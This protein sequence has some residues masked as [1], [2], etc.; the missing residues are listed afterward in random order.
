MERRDPRRSIRISVAAA[1]TWWVTL[2]MAPA[3]H[4]QLAPPAAPPENPVTPEKAVLGKIL[5]WDEQ[6]S[7]DNTVACGTCHRPAQGG[8]DRRFIANPGPDGVRPSQDD[9]FGSPGVIRSDVVNQYEPDP[10]HGFLALSTAR[11]ANSNLMAGYHAE[12][13][14]DGRAPT[15]FVDPQTGTISIASGGALESQSLVPIV[16]SIEMGHAARDWDEVTAKLAGSRPLALAD[17]LPADVAAALAG[18]PS[19]ADLFAT[20]FGDPAI[21][22]ERIAFALAT[23]EREAIP[24]QT[25]WDD[26]NAG[27]GTALTPRQQSGLNLFTGKANCAACH[28]LGLFTDD[29][30][31]NIGLRDPAT[32]PGREAI[33]GDHGDRGRMKVPSLRNAG[34]RQRFMHTGQFVD[35]NQVVDFYD[36]GGDFA[37]NRD[38]AIVRLRLSRREKDELVDF[39]VNG[40][41]DARAAA[42]LAPFDR[43]RLWSERGTGNPRIFGHG[44]RGSGGFEPLVIAA[45]PPNL[46]NVDF[47]FGVWNALGGSLAWA[48]L[49]YASEPPNTFWK[50]VPLSVDLDQ[51]AYVLPV[52]TLG[53]GPGGGYASFVGALPDDPTLLGLAFFGEWF[54]TDPVAPGGFAASAGIEFAIF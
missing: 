30:Y 1:A 25:P 5:F 35:L 45:T 32:D 48:L 15:T 38:P 11:L 3:A 8:G 41:T 17:Q 29:T 19:Y 6:L 43:P 14:W 47:K 34:L 9:L 53:A 18:D 36:R 26:W 39:V 22:A 40:L 50:G 54:V 7:S 31:R 13:F 12:L 28:P 44:S 24:D 37:D 4:G 52:A 42:E 10:L 20:A 46:G 27:D 51:L 21:T 23:F 33:T 49:S 2:S 16:S